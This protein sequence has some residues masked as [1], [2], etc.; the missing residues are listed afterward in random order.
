[1]PTLHVTGSVTSL[2]TLPA[3]QHGRG[4]FSRTFLA[5]AVT[6]GSGIGQSFL[7]ALVDISAAFSDPPKAR[8]AETISVVGGADAGNHV[9]GVCYYCFKQGV[10]QHPQF[11][12]HC[13]RYLKE[14]MKME[15][16]YPGTADSHWLMQLSTLSIHAGNSAQSLATRVKG[17]SPVS[18]R[19]L[20]LC[21]L[22]R[23]V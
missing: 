5:C 6:P 20:C 3:E 10:R 8:G 13:Q 18:L 22:K 19:D 21:N 16:E 12:H 4:P 17:G 1:M 7:E 9:F 14:F 2:P 11:Q 23:L 15:E